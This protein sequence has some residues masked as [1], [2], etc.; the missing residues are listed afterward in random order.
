MHHLDPRTYL[1]G[2]FDRTS[3]IKVSL[4]AFSK[5]GGGHDGAMLW[6]KLAAGAVSILVS[7][8]AVASGAFVALAAAL[9]VLTLKRPPY[10][11]A[12][13]NVG[14]FAM[15]VAFAVATLIG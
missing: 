10:Y 6:L 1:R 3:N 9:V 13:T 8:V 11:T 4:H 2:T 5:R 12:A 14:R 15:V 7:N